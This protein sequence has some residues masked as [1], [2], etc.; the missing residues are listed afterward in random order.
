MMLHEFILLP[1]M[2]HRMLKLPRMSPSQRSCLR[3]KTSWDCLM[4]CTSN[5]ISIKSCK[6]RHFFSSRS[7]SQV[8]TPIIPRKV[9]W[10]A[11]RKIKRPADSCSY[12]PKIWSSKAKR[13]KY[14]SKSPKICIYCLIIHLNQDTKLKWSKIGLKP[15]PTEWM[16]KN[17]KWPQ[18]S[19]LLSS[20]EDIM[21]TNGHR[22][23]KN[24]N[25][26]KTAL[27]DW[28]R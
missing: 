3:R 24:R 15:Q 8:W 22:H 23:F 5:L 16:Q 13:T 6:I 19:N 21:S 14:R 2:L 20:K 10:K 7:N 17:K 12:Q 4:S 28:N 11:P 26:K 27:N 1:R 9:M 18:I 25:R